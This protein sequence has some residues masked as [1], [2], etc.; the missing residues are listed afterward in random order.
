ML[1]A[2]KWP[3]PRHHA[4]RLTYHPVMP[5]LMSQVGV[6]PTTGSGTVPVPVLELI[7]P[8]ACLSTDPAGVLA[9]ACIGGK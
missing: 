3:E 9:P 5:T 1:T 7:W 4:R 6:P 2:Q 8:H